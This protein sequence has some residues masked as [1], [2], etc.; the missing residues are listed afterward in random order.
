MRNCL[1]KTPRVLTLLG[2]LLLL[3]SCKSVAPLYKKT[4]QQYIFTEQETFS[5]PKKQYQQTFI[6]PSTLKEDFIWGINGHPIDSESYRAKGSLDLQTQLLKEFQL[7]YYR[8]NITLN[9]EGEVDYWKGDTQR[10]KN[11]LKNTTE[12][13]IKILPLILLRDFDFTMSEEKAYSIAKKKTSGFA[14]KYKDQLDVYALGNEM[15]LK[16]DIDGK[17]GDKIAHYDKKKFDVWIAFLKGMAAGIREVDPTAK[18]IING[19]GRHRY[20]YYEYIKQQQ[21]DYD[22]IGFHWYSEMGNVDEPYLSEKDGLDIIQYMHEQFNK[23]IWI[24]E[25]NQH[26]GI[27]KHSENHQAFWIDHFIDNLKGRSYIKAF[28]VY[29]LLDQPHLDDGEGYENPRQAYFGLIDWVT[30]YTSYRYRPAAITYKYKIEEVKRGLQ[31][32]V[33]AIGQVLS[34]PNETQKKLLTMLQK[35]TSPQLTLEFAYTTQ[36]PDALLRASITDIYQTLLNRNPT[37][38]EE[39]Y[40][41]KQTKNESSKLSIITGLLSSQE[42][43][44]NAIVEGY[45]ANNPYPFQRDG[46]FNITPFYK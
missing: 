45:I 22:I 18:L 20:G 25:I 14:R 32:Y 8:V 21:V 46:F 11:T 2:I 42:F 35:D 40:W 4:K 16:V 27:D 15:D 44:K 30:P 26:W 3:A 9:N 6:K 37:Q 29:E 34:L 13:N 1:L 24:T 41:K 43:Y 39:I 28:F 19:A 5:N 23:P 31:H 33:T 38:K 36:K 12:A 7:S 10:W 17:E